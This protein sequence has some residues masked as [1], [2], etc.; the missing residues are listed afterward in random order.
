MQGYTAYLHNW[1]FMSF[2]QGFILLTED[3]PDKRDDD[4]THHFVVHTVLAVEVKA[5]IEVFG[6]LF[7]V[8]DSSITI[9]EEAPALCLALFGNAIIHAPFHLLEMLD[10]LLSNGEVC[11]AVL[12]RVEILEGA[13]FQDFLQFGHPQSRVHADAW[14]V[15]LLH[16]I[17]ASHACPDNQIGLV[18]GAEVLE[19]RQRFFR[20]YGNVRGDDS[21]L[22]HLLGKIRNRVALAARSK[23]MEV[24]YC[25]HCYRSF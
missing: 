9:G 8:I 24:N 4:V 25:F 1:D 5:I 3:F 18:G 10:G 20:V 22:C 19:K 21:A 11:P 16:G 14:I 15:C 17:H 13:C 6:E 2:L 7:L 23:A 12:C